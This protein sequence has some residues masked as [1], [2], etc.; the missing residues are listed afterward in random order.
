MKRPGF[1]F[2]NT[3][4]VLCD[5]E[6]SRFIFDSI[7]GPEIIYR[8]SLLARLF[9]LSSV[10]SFT[11][12]HLFRAVTA[13]IKTII[14]MRF[15]GGEQNVFVLSLQFLSHFKCFDMNLSVQY[16]ECVSVRQHTSHTFSASYAFPLLFFS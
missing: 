9:H 8:R 10:F 14:I 7:Q 6:I 15:W 13:V 1:M 16:C 4:H 5:A 3:F 2:A 11:L 12:C